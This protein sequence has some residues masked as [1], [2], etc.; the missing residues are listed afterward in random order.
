MISGNGR[1]KI[2]IWSRAIAIIIGA[3]ATFAAAL[4]GAFKPTGIEARAVNE[5]L[6]QDIR[7][8]QSY[9]SAL[10]I[11]NN[12]M[13]E[14]LNNEIIKIR[15]EL[16]STR[17]LITGFLF[18]QR[19]N[20]LITDRQKENAVKA[21][22]GS[23]NRSVKSNNHVLEKQHVKK[24]HYKPTLKEPRRYSEIIDSISNKFE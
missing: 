10:E 13:R 15:N 18:A 24:K 17:S 6:A 1:S 12:E 20:S 3:S 22:V 9:V 19:R 14:D 2:T 4:I 23:V 16:V 7:S 5:S 21:I 8:L 11:K